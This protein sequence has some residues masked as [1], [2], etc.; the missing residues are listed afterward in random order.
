MKHTLKNPANN[1]AML[2]MVLAM[3]FTFLACEEKGGKAEQAVPEEVAKPQNFK[4]VKIGSQ[5]WM[6]ENL[7]IKTG[8]SWCYD[9]DESNKKKYGRLYDWNTAKTACPSGWHLPS[10]EDW[11]NLINYAGGRAVAGKKLKSKS[12]WE[13]RVDIY[14]DEPSDKPSGTAF[15]TSNGTDDYG[16]SAKPGDITPYGLWWSAHESSDVYATYWAMG[17]NF[18]DGVDEGSALK[19]EKRSVRCIQ[20][21]TAPKTAT[22][23][24]NYS[25]ALQTHYP[26]GTLGEAGK[27]RPVEMFFQ[28]VLKNGNSYVIVGKSKTKAAEDAFSGTLAISS[29][30]AGGSC[31]SGETEIKG[32]YD[33]NEK[34]SKT[35]GHFVGSF[36]ACEKSGKL[37]KAS[38]KGDW[39]KHANG[40]KTPCSF[41]L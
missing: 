1:F 36:T 4:T 23:T 38:F 8:N 28:K 14:P 10:E 22:P 31:G 24:A 13:G 35:S 29:Q 18:R 15:V 19:N 17:Y 26:K 30:T 34:A 20:T 7:N 40:S 33:L 25:P 37:S 41:G 12:G 39:V 21:A 27:T 11:L 32:S 6:A 5:T 3:A 9:N 2:L 16:F